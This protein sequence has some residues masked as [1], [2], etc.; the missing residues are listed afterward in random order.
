MQNAATSCFNTK[1]LLDEIRSWVEIESPTTEPAAVNRMVDKVEADA[2]AAGT[3]MERIPGRDGYGD[4][5]LISSPWG[6][7]DKPGILV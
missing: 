7:A 2:K 4:H 5:L 1:S 6:A 3:R